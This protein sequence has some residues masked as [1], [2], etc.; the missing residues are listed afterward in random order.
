MELQFAKAFA[1]LESRGLKI[2]SKWLIDQLDFIAETRAEEPL[3]TKAKMNLLLGAY[4]ETVEIL[5]KVDEDEITRFIKN[6]ARF[7]VFPP[8][9]YSSNLVKTRKVN[10]ERNTW[11]VK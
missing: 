5:S 7:L 10:K 1:E 2:A 8:L 9:N 3:L 4:G 11:E 6:Y